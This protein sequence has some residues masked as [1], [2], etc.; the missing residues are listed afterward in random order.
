MLLSGH[1]T[2]SVFERYNIDAGDQLAGAL[3]EIAAYVDRQPKQGRPTVPTL[4]RR[5]RRAR[6]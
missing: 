1:A 5:R 3:D 2:E 4:P 6:R